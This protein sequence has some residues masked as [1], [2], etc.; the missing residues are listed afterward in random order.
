MYTTVARL[1]LG[2][3]LVSLV[4]AVSVQPL[5]AQVLY[6]SIVGTVTDQTG[7]MVPKAT[8]TITN[9]AT[10][11]VRETATDEAGRYSLLNVLAGTYDLKVTAS[12]FKPFTE[13]GIAVTINTLTRSDVKLQV[14]QVVETI[15]VEASATVLQTE[16]ATVQAEIGTKAVENLPLPRFRNYQSLID[17]VPGATPGRFQNAITDTPA[18]ALT[19]NVNGT[20]RNNN[21]TRLDGATNVYIWLPHH[22][23]YVAPAETVQTVNIATNNFDA[24]QGMAGG[25]AI[26]V[27]TKS[28]SNELHGSAFWLH[29]NQ[30]LQARNFFQAPGVAKPRSTVN[31]TGGTI[32]GPIKKNKLFFFGGWE[33][34]RERGGRIR[35]QS[36]PTAAI[37]GGNFSATGTT[38]YDPLTGTADGRGRTAFPGGIIPAQRQSAI[39]Q[40]LVALTPS[41][42]QPGEFANFFVGGTQ[43]VNRDNFDIKLN[44][45]RTEKHVIWGKYSAMDAQVTGP[46]SLGA[47]GGPCVCDGGSGAGNTLVQLST[48]GHTW[49]FTPNFLIDTTLGW[50]RMGQVVKGP[51]FGKNFGLEVLGIPGTN[52]PDPRQSGL[53]IFSVSGYTGL[54]NTEGWSPIF[55]NDQ[56]FTFTQNVSWIKGAHDLRFGFDAIHHMLNHWQPELGSGPR[57]SFNFGGGV[58]ALNGGPSPN[59][60]NAYAQFLLGLPSSL[61]KSVQFIKMSVLEWQFASY[62]RDRWRIS[63]KLTMTLGLRWEYYPLMTRGY[64]G[65]ERYDAKTNQVFIGGFGNVPRNAGVTTSKKLFAPR[66]GIAYRWT[67]KTVIRTGYGITYNPMVFGRP[68]R[69]FYPLTVGSDF[70]A[71]NS[72]RVAVDDRGVELPI[73][74]GIPEICCPDISSG[75]IPLPPS[76][77]MRTPFLGPLKRGYIQSWNLIVERRLPAEVVASVGYVGTQTIRSFAD[78]DINAGRVIGA[79][80]AGRPQFA[81]FGR[82]T[83]TLLWQGWVQANYHSLQATVNRNFRNGLMLKGAYTWSKAINWTDDDGWTGVSWNQP[84]LLRRNRANAG[85]NT[86]HIFQLGYVYELPFGKGKKRA[87]SP[88]ASA[89]LGGWQVNGHF[90][91]FTGRT[92]MTIG[93][94]APLSLPG[95]TQTADQVKPEVKKLGGIGRG[96]PFFDPAAFSTNTRNPDGSPRFGTTGRN[97]LRGPGVVNLDLSVFRNFQL[98]ER[99]KLEFRAEAYNATNT[100]HFENPNTNAADPVAFMSITSTTRDFPE[101]Q[102]RFGLRLQF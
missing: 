78:L 44:W 94:G 38:I 31:I 10:N 13:T 57:G 43:V 33:G 101:R 87:T 1:S 58:T 23:V 69:G 73:T 42:N 86:P 64:G 32:G 37:R 16:T 96:V 18:R 92:N 62:V 47:A 63:P 74:R 12:G 89:I 5:Q 29:D 65:I 22:T 71:P 36:V 30:K 15:T 4:A 75:I 3:L 40:K 56:S 100:P 66:L 90:S 81:P 72:F 34:Y 11:Q 25:A 67:D 55:R 41:P 99:F 68:L 61:G 24:E 45:N 52:G 6:G 93:G 76:A 46:F 14:G 85:F 19:T 2:L 51:D 98:T 91:S 88:A 77:L 27:V 84:E 48:L 83:S 7:A 21:N 54:G 28:G 35:N 97:I 70:S 102:F 17:L 9:T 50:S 20:N 26:S 53:P 95:S 82:A 79:G 8:V 80:N 39:I 49:T 59:R 60:F